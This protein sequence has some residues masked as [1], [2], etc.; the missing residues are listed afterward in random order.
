MIQ[1]ISEQFE[2]VIEEKRQTIEATQ[3]EIDEQTMNIENT[4]QAHITVNNN[5]AS[6]ANKTLY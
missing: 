6:L 2:G 5:I 3:K 4:I 1:S